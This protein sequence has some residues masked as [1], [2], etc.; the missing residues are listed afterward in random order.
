MTTTLKMSIKKG[1]ATPTAIEATLPVILFLLHLIYLFTKVRLTLYK[2][3]LF[4][5]PVISFLI[6]VKITF[7]KAFITLFT[8]LF[9]IL[10]NLLS[11]ACDTLALPSCYYQEQFK[12]IKAKA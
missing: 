2:V 4:I 1:K 11:V 8:A 7:L 9:F 10:L 3:N 12:K 6:L 5:Y